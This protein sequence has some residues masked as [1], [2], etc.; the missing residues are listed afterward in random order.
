MSKSSS[1]KAKETLPNK[2]KNLLGISK[3]TASPVAGA[4]PLR[5]TEFFFTSEVLRELSSE[6]PTSV[7]LKKLT[8]ICEIVQTKKLEENAIEVLWLTV[9]DLLYAQ[10][11][12][13]SRSLSMRFL[14]CLIVGQYEE[15]GIM[16][17]YFF[18]VIQD[19]D[20]AEDVVPRFDAFKAL[21]DVG[22]D[23]YNFEEEVGSFIL[24]W[25]GDVMRTSCIKDFL[26]LLVN[27]VKYNA[28]YLDQDIVSG[29][30]HH[31]CNH[32]CWTN[33]QGDIEMCIKVLDAIVCYS[34]LP[35]DSLSHFINTL[36]TTVNISKE[37][38]CK[39]SWE[40]MRKLL[41]THLGHSAIYTM[42][43]I[44]QDPGN[45]QRTGLLRGAV[46][47]IGMALWGHKRVESLKNSPSS[48]LP[49]FKQALQCQHQTIAYEVL[50]SVSRLVKK[51]GSE[52]QLLTWDLV[53]DIVERVL[54]MIESKDVKEDSP[55]AKE[56]A[57]ELHE[58]LTCAEEQSMRSE[59][60]GDPERLY[61][62]IE[63]CYTTRPEES[64]L[65]LINHRA[66]YI[67]PMTEGLD[68]AVWHS[69]SRSLL[70]QW[71]TSASCAR[72][73]I[74]AVSFVHRGSSSADICQ[75]Y[76]SFV[77]VRSM[78][79][80]NTICQ[81]LRRY[82]DHPVV[83][84][85]QEDLPG[86]IAGL[87]LPCH[88]SQARDQMTSPYANMAVVRA[89]RSLPAGLISLNVALHLLGHSINNVVFVKLW[90]ATA[91][92]GYITRRVKMGLTVWQI[93]MRPFENRV[94]SFAMQP[95][96]DAPPIFKPPLSEADLADV[97][98]AVVGVIDIFIAKYARL[99][100]AHAVKAFELLVGFMQ[101][102][103]AA[104]LTAS[105][106][107]AAA[108]GAVLRLFCSLRS[109]TLHRV[110]VV[111]P[112][113]D[114]RASPY[115]LCHAEKAVAAGGTHGTASP[116]G[117]RSPT[118]VA[119]YDRCRTK[120]M[121]VAAV[122]A[123]VVQCLA[124]E[125]EWSV[126]SV[127]LGSL[128]A[129]LQNK[130]FVLATNANF[131]LLCGKLVAMATDKRLGYPDVLRGLPPKFS[132]SDFQG[133]VYPILAALASYHAYVDKP[134]QVTL[135]KSLEEG[136]LSKCAC[137]CVNAIIVCMLEMQETMMRQL[138]EVLLKLSPDLFNS[139]MSS[140]RLQVT[141]IKSLEEGR[142]SKCACMCVNAIIVCMLEMQET[143]MRQ[144]PEVLLKLS[145]ISA[146]RAIAI[147]ML[148]FLACLIHLPRLYANFVE[149]QYMSVFAI[150]APYTNP[151]KF[152]H[153]TA[154]LA[155]QVIALWF[156]KCRIIFRKDFVRFIT[157]G[158][159][160]NVLLPFE[161][162]A[163]YEKYSDHAEEV[164]RRPRSGSFISDAK[165]AKA[166]SPTPIREQQKPIVDEAMSNFHME[167]TE[168]C[169][170]MMARYTFALYSSQPQ[171]SPV[172]QFLL[173]GGQNMTWLVGNKLVTITTSGGS[174]K[175]SKQV[176]DRGLITGARRQVERIIAPARAEP[177]FRLPSKRSSDDSLVHLQKDHAGSRGATAAH[178][179][180]SDASLRMRQ[181][182]HTVSVM[183]GRRA[184]QM[185]RRMEKPPMAPLVQPTQT[186][187]INPAFVFLQ[188]YHSAY[189]MD[190]N[191]RP[192]LLP[193]GDVNNRAV[194]NLDRI[195]PYETHKI[196]VLYVGA[197]QVNDEAAIL[198]NEY[199]SSRYAK[200]LEGLGELTHLRRTNPD[201][202]FLGGLETDGS[203]GEFAYSWRDDITQAIFH[204]ATLMP[205]KASD[206]SCNGKKLHIGNNFVSIVYNDSNEPYKTGTIRGQF[207][208]VSI[209]IKPLDHESNMVSVCAKEEL[210]EIG[211]GEPKI[212]SDRHLPI[213][214]RQLALHADLA[215]KVYQSQQL[216]H[217][218]IYASK[219]LERLR[220][221]KRIRSK[222]LQEGFPSQAKPSGEAGAGSQSSIRNIEDFTTYL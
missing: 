113:G 109:D 104:P 99:P 68:R 196:G 195:P 189:F 61:D 58:L 168:T 112:D 161:E 212:I 1:G 136:R 119:A 128:P 162:Q 59:Y 138:P 54:K 173:D 125:H 210:S 66:Q 35:T 105:P 98:A 211:H 22:K 174:L 9:A 85:L 140:G 69:H 55:M 97:K 64:V 214:A 73:V 75:A 25:M 91:E 179:N 197:G 126:L 114:A 182:G 115:L 28:T 44:L 63:Q 159:K 103:Y 156:I 167:L 146:T 81:P 131:E 116:A 42:C 139:D 20:V 62:C 203:D 106:T 190:N 70:R 201:H 40:L 164:T 144:L 150:A 45:L 108:R 77:Q 56:L 4:N 123:V 21:C 30:V 60:A 48:V 23:V 50:L 92:C 163:K 157:K 47:Y 80:V 132:R 102:S 160:A 176:T 32:I 153:Y 16:R 15:L 71:R 10:S 100:S 89:G 183:G 130:S 122:M 170:D 52:L 220:Q 110:C 82:V 209:I 83:V 49:S 216:S 33:S 158:L 117:P 147:P 96:A 6:S 177:S 215:S 120:T 72:Y 141:L 31:T 17:A 206:V 148:E 94:T 133:F 29:I 180:E 198:S 13:D 101:G 205:N 165:D 57:R 191:E 221:I 222:V 152:S 93:C 87:P 149:E 217:H 178:A 171:R 11:P 19:H 88:T 74:A 151:A 90:V 129:I 2:I 12:Q 111:A 36:C 155:H 78:P 8:E 142:L 218:D 67:H 65:R 193:H 186:S 199:G 27:L 135:I 26:A 219:W 169:L 121:S 118:V 39:A 34:Y 145:Q 185:A 18:K 143:M 43:R 127:V 137:M 24:G 38:L 53:M 46:F 200:F 202:T 79:S 84:S 51:Y 86:E 5:T 134:L 107:L 95:N 208:F 172:A 181:R 76:E 184:Y 37:D 41:G 124:S 204:V 188:L 166:I 154:S 194:K 14:Q 213:L 207:R 175:M 7:R 187:G 3:G 192:L